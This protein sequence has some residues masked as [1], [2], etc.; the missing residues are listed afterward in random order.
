MVK[1]TFLSFAIEFSFKNSRKVEHVRILN[2]Q[3]IYIQT[4]K[5]SLF[6]V[7]FPSSPLNSLTLP[8]ELYPFIFTKQD[9]SV[10]LVPLH[11][12][13]FFQ[14]TKTRAHKMLFVF[15]ICRIL[16]VY[17][18]T[19]IIINFFERLFNYWLKEERDI[20]RHLEECSNWILS[21]S[22]SD[23]EWWNPCSRRW[24]W[25]CTRSYSHGVVAS[26]ATSCLP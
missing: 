21:R 11:L 17:C 3:K 16:W 5:Y 23:F 26:V 9:M 8:E 24:D 2:L 6:Y 13:I 15:N 10:S 25:T 19:K 12:Q 14:C 22:L 7:F 4:H 20:Y 18:S 1:F